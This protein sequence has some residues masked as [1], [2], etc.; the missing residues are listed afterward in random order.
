MDL[1]VIESPYAGHSTWPWPFDFLGDRIERWRNVWYARRCMFDSLAR[2]EAPLAAHLLYTQPGI[3]DD[4]VPGERTLGMR[5]GFA[6]AIHAKKRVF[7]VD[8]G[9][10]PGMA[11]ARAAASALGQ[12]IEFRTIDHRPIYVDSRFA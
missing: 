8:R 5:A 6:W 4:D 10:S 1:V 11:A 7:Y 9:M 12:Q 3:L 2:G